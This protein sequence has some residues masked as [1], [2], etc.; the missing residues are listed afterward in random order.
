MSQNHFTVLYRRA[1]S[2]NESSTSVVINNTTNSNVLLQYPVKL[3]LTSSNFNFS[4]ST[5]DGSDTRIL[6][7]DNS[8]VIP[9]Y[10]RSFDKIGQTAE[11]WA[12]VDSIPAN[13][14]KTIFISTGN[15][16][17]PFTI[18]PTGKFTRPTS[19]VA[20]G[21]AENMVYDSATSKYYIVTSSTTSGPVKLYS[22]SSPN[23]TWTDEGIILNFGSS[24]QWDD[25]FLYAPHLIKE[26]STWY[27]FYSGGPDATENSHSVGYATASNVTG[28]YTRFASNPVLPFTGTSTF[29][30]YRACESYIYYSNILN[31]WVML[32]M[33]DSGS[34]VASEIEKIGYATSPTIDGTWTKYS[35]NPII[36]FVTGP[37]WRDRSIAA[38]PFA[39]E[40][41]D[42]A[43]IFITGG[44]PYTTGVFKTTDYVT[45]TEIGQVFGTGPTGSFDED[46]AFRG[47]ITRFGDTYYF[48]YAGKTG[49][50]TFTWAVAS[51][52]AISTAKGFDPLQVFDYYD[53]FSGVSLDADLWTSPTGSTSGTVTVSGGVATLS[54]TSGSSVHRTISGH[55]EFGIGYMLEAL[56]RHSTATSGGTNAGEIG[57]ADESD[58]N[59]ASRLWQY[60]TSFAKKETR[61]S[62]GGSTVSDMAQA[63]T[64]GWVTRRVAWIASNSFGFQND[65]NSWET[66]GTN[67]PDFVMKP[68]VFAFRGTANVSYEVDWI[69]VRKYANPEPTVTIG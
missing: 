37:D 30:Q 63:L 54:I 6:D 53:D 56:T 55:R 2:G 50:S 58:R 25:T 64:T 47:A 66:I 15:S 17:A 69:I 26:G 46:S 18:P 39:L 9:Y 45:F 42:V 34:G 32:Y 68:W 40:I 4:L 13:G 44:D 49:V 28:P 61:T 12:R 23:G 59:P 51:M 33:G 67:I 24:G 14:T 62:S 57:F 7:S 21:L 22:S 38:D 52:P 41:E 31:K 60:D 3:L 10:I 1:Y 20:S 65:N 11:I 43:Y 35:G 16:T 19:S 27:L 29:D 36:S 5:T 8:T 48:P